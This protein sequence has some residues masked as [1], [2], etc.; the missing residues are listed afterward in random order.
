MGQIF[1]KDSISVA[2]AFTT[3]TLLL[4]TVFVTHSGLEN[5]IVMGKVFWV[6][7][8]MF[9]CGV[10]TL[11]TIWLSRGKH[12]SPRIADGLVAALTCV[13]L[14]TYDWQFNP[15]PEKLLFGG[16]LVVMW[17]VFRYYMSTTPSLCPAFLFVLMGTGFAEAVWGMLQL[18]GE[19][20]SN[21]SLFRLTGSFFNPGPYSGYLAVTLPV[22]LWGMLKYSHSAK[23]FAGACLAAIAIVLP[24]GMSRSAWVAATLS[25]GWV[26]WMERIGWATTRVCFVKHKRW[27]VPAIVLVAVLTASFSIAMFNMK[28]NSAEGRLLMWKVTAKTITTRPVAGTGLGSFPSIYAASQAAYFKGSHVK[29]EEKFVAG[30]PEYAFNEYLQ[31]GIEQGMAGLLAFVALLGTLIYHGAKNGQTGAAGGILSLSV[32]AFSSYPLQLPSFWIALVVLGIICLTDKKDVSKAAISRGFAAKP[33]IAA[34]S[35]A[36]ILLFLL[37][38]ERYGAYEKWLTMKGLYNTKAYQA[39]VDDYLSLHG[40][41]G[42]KP[43]FL[44]EEAQCLSKTERHT[45]AAGVFERAERLSSDPMILYMKAKNLQRLGKYK[46]A[47]DVLLGAIDV[48]PERLY[49]Y[50]LLMKLYEETG[51]YQKDKLEKAA[52]TVLLKEPKV[53][54]SA[55]KEMKNYAKQVLGGKNRQD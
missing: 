2:V 6:H 37:G 4:A 23:V 30:C 31:I 54:S 16:Q 33:F 11:T 53:N 17:F 13:T 39:V 12:F 18:H 27:A 1:K 26:Y 8:L 19:T 5:G 48:L 43:E 22:C 36:G 20:N 24:A 42:H 28:R 47:E 21:H 46:E 14:L 25:C 35:I 55:I 51:F 34:M 38:Q 7:A 32:F 15:E 9:A 50:Y 10:C 52:S 3:G 40:Q 29:P 45:E 41:L 44:F 49:P